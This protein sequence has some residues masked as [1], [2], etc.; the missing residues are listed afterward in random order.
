MAFVS[1]T[2]QTLTSKAGNGMTIA[3]PDVCKTPTPGG[4]VPIPYPNIQLQSNLQQANKTDAKA[5]T[6]D[7]AAKKLQKQAIDNLKQ[8]TGIEVKSATAAVL[9][10]YSVF[11]KS[12]GDEAGTRTNT[13][14]ARR[15]TA[16]VR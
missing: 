4:P 15:N 9:M 13:A 6:G 8:Q 14:S 10:G 3:F 2:N 5:K 16:Y 1:I 11:K 12:V 7:K